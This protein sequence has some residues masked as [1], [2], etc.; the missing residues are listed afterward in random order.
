[1]DNKEIAVEISNAIDMLKGYTTYGRSEN[2]NRA[3]VM[4][5]SLYKKL[6]KE[7]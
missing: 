3:E 5:R 7:Q 4:L 1:M 6:T 2:A